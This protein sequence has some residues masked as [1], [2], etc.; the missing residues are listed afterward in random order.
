MSSDQGAAGGPR[1]TEA[2]LLGEPL[3]RLHDYFRNQHIWSSGKNAFQE[4]NLLQV[5]RAANIGDALGLAFLK[6]LKDDGPF[7]V[8]EPKPPPWMPNATDWS[9]RIV[10][11]WITWEAWDEYYQSH[12][13]KRGDRGAAPRQADQKA[14]SPGQAKTQA[15]GRPRPWKPTGRAAGILRV[16]LRAGITSEREG[17]SQDIIAGKVDDGLT[18]RS[19]AE[20]FRR[21]RQARLIDAGKGSAAGTW[22]TPAGIEAA[23]RLPDP[24]E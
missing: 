18:R 9:G 16:M 1:F 19:L 3:D 22:L 24:A 10:Y 8:D 17:K 2:E 21:L 11:L 4:G 6:W 20:P 5:L 12:R 23:R 14:R 7:R 13:Q 15:A